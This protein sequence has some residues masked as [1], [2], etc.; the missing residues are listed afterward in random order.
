MRQGGASCRRGVNLPLMWIHANGFIKQIIFKSQRNQVMGASTRGIVRLLMWQF[1][2]PV[3]WAN[4]IAW[5]VAGFLMSRW[6]GGFAYH[7]ELEFWLF[8]AATSLALLSAI[9]TVG[10]QSYLVARSKPVAALRYE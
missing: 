6:L 10:L 2:K 9:L 4:V 8:P 7:V 1:I 5:P 3:L